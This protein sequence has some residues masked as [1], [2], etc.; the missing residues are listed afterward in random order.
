M[1]PKQLLCEFAALGLSPVRTS[2]LTGSDAYFVAFRVVGA[3]PGARRDQALPAPK[4][5]EQPH[6][7]HAAAVAAG[8]DQMV[9]DG[10]SIASPARASRRVAR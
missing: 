2:R 6:P 5:L 9:E 8:E 7:P 4:A 10:R 3:A 1:P